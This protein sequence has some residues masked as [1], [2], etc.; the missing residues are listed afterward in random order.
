MNHDESWQPDVSGT[1]DATREDPQAAVPF[2]RRAA[3]AFRHA[4]RSIPALVPRGSEVLVLPDLKVQ[5]AELEL[6]R[7][8]LERTQGNRTAAAELLGIHA[9]TLRRRL[10][11]MDELR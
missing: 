3:P 11:Q 9:R 10:R 2:E 5:T 4:P 6:I 8:A 7:R 1:P